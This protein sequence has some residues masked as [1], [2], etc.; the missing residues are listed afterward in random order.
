MNLRSETLNV[1]DACGVPKHREIDFKREKVLSF[2]PGS[3]A[4]DSSCPSL[5]IILDLPLFRAKIFLGEMW[6][7]SRYILV[8]GSSSPKGI[9]RLYL[10]IFVPLSPY[11]APS[12]PLS[13]HSFKNL[14]FPRAGYDAEQIV[15]IYIM[16]GLMWQI[17]EIIVCTR[18]YMSVKIISVFLRTIF[19]VCS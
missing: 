3:C 6:C 19:D 10:L 1:L 2:I 17:Y 8:L 4:D 14:T 13:W 12:N 7:L 11:L 15:M 16:W 18:A 9:L 5:R